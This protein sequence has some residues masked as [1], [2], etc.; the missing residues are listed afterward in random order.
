MYRFQEKQR[1]FYHHMFFL[2]ISRKNY[3]NGISFFTRNFP[4]DC[5]NQEVKYFIIL[6]FLAKEQKLRK[7]YDVGTSPQAGSTRLNLGWVPGS[8]HQSGMISGMNCIDSTMEYSVHTDYRIVLFAL[9]KWLYNQ[10]YF[11][12]QAF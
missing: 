9:N 7:M 5:T 11:F 4:N 3:V 1:F 8:N 10:T 2:I 6:F 12:G